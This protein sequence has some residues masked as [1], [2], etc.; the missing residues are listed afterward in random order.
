MAKL[1]CHLLIHT[2]ERPFACGQCQESFN[3]KWRL[4]EHLLKHQQSTAKPFSCSSCELAF[5]TKSSLQRH[6]QQKHT[7]QQSESLLYACES[8]AE[9][10]KTEFSLLLH[11]RQAHPTVPFPK[12]YIC[13]RCKK[14]FALQS[15]LGRHLKGTCKYLPPTCRAPAPLTDC[16]QCHQ[17][18]ATGHLLQ[19]HMKHAH[20]PTAGE[21]IQCTECGVWMRKRYLNGHMLKVHQVRNAQQFTC[22]VC[23]FSFSRIQA[24]KSHVKR[25][26]TN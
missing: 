26:V 24:Y 16:V 5:A 7:V 20:S 9:S 18:F 10:F 12:S 4:A 19:N 11:H 8:C 21:S 1:E 3:R 22:D 25:H 2:K 13:E 14:R 6:F 17:K 23:L 15:R